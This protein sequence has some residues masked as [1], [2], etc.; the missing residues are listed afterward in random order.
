MEDASTVDDQKSK[1]I[2]KNLAVFYTEVR[3]V[4]PHF[5]RNAQGSEVNLVLGG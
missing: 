2:I 5:L 1:N 4:H 3:S